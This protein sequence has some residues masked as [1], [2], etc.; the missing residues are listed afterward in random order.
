[1]QGK[2]TVSNVCIQLQSTLAASG[3]FIH[4]KVK[5]ESSIRTVLKQSA[6]QIQLE[7]KLSVIANLCH[8][9]PG[10]TYGDMPYLFLGWLG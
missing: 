10:I 1:M 5:R 8:K 2:K 6:F 3:S 7:M 9:G 4:I